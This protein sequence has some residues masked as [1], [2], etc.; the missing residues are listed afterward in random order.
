MD[1]HAVGCRAHHVLVGLVVVGV[2]DCHAQVALPLLQWRRGRWRRRR[3]GRAGAPARDHVLDV[4]E[5][6]LVG[7]RVHSRRRGGL[8]RVEPPWGPRQGHPVGAREHVRIGIQR[9]TVAGAALAVHLRAVGRRAHHVLVGV[10]VVGIVDRHREVAQ[11]RE[12]DPSYR[13]VD[14][15][16]QG[17]LVRG[18]AEIEVYS[19]P[20]NVINTAAFRI[21][22]ALRFRIA[23]FGSL[24]LALDLVVR[25]ALNAI[26]P[27]VAAGDGAARRLERGISEGGDDTRA[28]AAASRCCAV[29]AR[30]QRKR[31]RRGRRRRVATWRRRR[32]RGRRQSRRERGRR[33]LL[34]MD[35]AVGASATIT[36]E[37]R[38]LGRIEEAARVFLV[39]CLPARDV[40]GGAARELHARGAALRH[41]LL[42]VA[43]EFGALLADSGARRAA[44]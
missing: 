29:L 40:K 43:V 3:R 8:K 10:V 31:R 37:P 9:G 21:S 15:R 7:I 11:G 36:V 22:G 12:L 1:L 30:Y 41:G 5:A 14:A 6:A 33:A 16:F 27:L 42:P 2:P 4:Q 23:E 19:I 28:V 39:V 18:F 24:A 20:L 38:Q 35:P 25:Y 44:Q 32:E 13:A 26:L 17:K 34:F